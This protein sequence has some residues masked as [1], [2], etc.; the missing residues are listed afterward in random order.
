MCNNALKKSV[1]VLEVNPGNPDE[2]REVKMSRYLAE[3]N[4]P[5]KH[6]V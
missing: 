5:S 4:C 1:L 3:G 6:G 2:S